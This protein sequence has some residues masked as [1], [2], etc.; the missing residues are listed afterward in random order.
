MAGRARSQTGAGQPNSGR[1]T[2]YWG[3]A[4]V[5]LLL[6]SAGMVT[7]P[8]ES[9]GVAFVRSFYEDNR[10]VIVVSQVIG[11]VAAVAFFV[12]ARGLQH[13]EWVGRAPWV[14]VCGSG[15][16]VAAVL[17]GVPPLVLCVL[18]RSGAANTI[19]TLATASDL[20]DV[21]L[22]AA[23]AAFAVSVT[24]AVGT[25]WLRALAAVV[26]VISGVRAVIVLTGGSALELAG[27][28]AFIVLI[29]SLSCFAWWSQRYARR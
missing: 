15:V 25:T 26:A 4:F 9:N 16:A 23:I 13:R 8:G 2:A 27:P 3:L 17:A 20:V 22:F 29:L 6:V 24:V 19:S 12:F 7:V 18:A 21:V 28:I 14:F 5:L 10:S 11:L 1:S